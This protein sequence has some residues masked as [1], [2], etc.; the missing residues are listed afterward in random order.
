MPTKGTGFI[1]QHRSWNIRNGERDMR[2]IDRVV[3][4]EDQRVYHANEDRD[5]G[6]LPDS[7][8][9]PSDEH[10]EYIKLEFVS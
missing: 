3:N 1:T 5:F 4:E 2:R 10:T 9:K 6:R 8:Q 7:F